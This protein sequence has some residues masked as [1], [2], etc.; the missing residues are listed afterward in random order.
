VLLLHASGRPSKQHAAKPL[1]LSRQ[2]VRAYS[3]FSISSHWLNE[4]I[5]VTQLTIWPFHSMRMIR[6][7]TCE[8]SSVMTDLVCRQ[9]WGGRVAWAARRRGSSRQSRHFWF[10]RSCWSQVRLSSAWIRRADDARNGCPG[11]GCTAHLLACLYAHA[12]G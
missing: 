7:H 8:V 4:H 3:K 10:T 11:L 1:C 2:H 9:T 5:R 6:I 12:P